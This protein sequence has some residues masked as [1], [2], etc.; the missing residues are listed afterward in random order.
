MTKICREER[1]VLTLNVLENELK[2]NKEIKEG[3]ESIE[4]FN[5]H[6][7]QHRKIELL[8]ELI[9]IYTSEAKNYVDSL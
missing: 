4:G 6:P 3:I 7:K 1:S 5:L 8:E 2:N 9:E